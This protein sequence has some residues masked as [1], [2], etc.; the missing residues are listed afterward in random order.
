MVQKL[1]ECNGTF[2]PNIRG[3]RW[4]LFFYLLLESPLLVVWIIPKGLERQIQNPPPSR[5]LLPVSLRNCV[6]ATQAFW[7]VLLYDIPAHAGLLCMT[8]VNVCW[9]KAGRVVLSVQVTVLTEGDTICLFPSYPKQHLIIPWEGKYCS[10]GQKDNISFQHIP[11]PSLIASSRE[12]G[13]PCLS[14][15]SQKQEPN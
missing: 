4:L 14:S 2:L 7:D 8:Q 13:S 9:G 5:R 3:R 10:A 15:L 12:Q 6:L 1:G 11:Q